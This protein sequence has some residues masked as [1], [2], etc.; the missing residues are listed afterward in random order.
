M[1]D[2]TTIEKYI[3]DDVQAALE[4]DESELAALREENNRLK[5]DNREM[6]EIV[7][8][9][10]NEGKMIYKRYYICQKRGVLRCLC[11]ECVQERSRAAVEKHR[12]T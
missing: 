5:Q 2:Y 10:V 1:S 7:E 4:N 11:F 3:L 8:D 6:V 9:F 12:S